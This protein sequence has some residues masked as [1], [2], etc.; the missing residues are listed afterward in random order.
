MFRPVRFEPAACWRAFLL[1][2]LTAVASAAAPVVDPQ[3]AAET[4]RLLRDAGVPGQCYLEFE[5]HALPRRGEERT[6]RGRLWT[7]RPHGALTLRLSLEDGAG[8]TL[9][10]L[11]ENGPRPQ[12]WRWTGSSVVEMPA[13]AWTT[14]LLPEVELSAFDLLMPFLFWPEAAYQGTDRVRGREARSFVFKAPVTGEVI[15][16]VGAARVFLDAQVNALLQYDLLDRSGKV[17]RTFSLVSLKRLDAMVMPKALEFRNERSRD[18]ARLQ[19]TAAML[20]VDFSSALFDPAALG[21]EI[22]APT[23]RKL[24]LE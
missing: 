17:A 22:S 23:G 13:S 9:R 14:P 10:F 6:Y 12:V 1:A 15:P 11:I 4:L 8:Q 18:K 5:L 19:F 20:G 3:E 24:A 2:V 16:D 21:Q 7:A